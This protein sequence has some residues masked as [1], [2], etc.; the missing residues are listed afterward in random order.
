MSDEHDSEEEEMAISLIRNGSDS[1][2]RL[3][4]VAGDGEYTTC[5]CSSGPITKDICL[6]RTFKFKKK[7]YSMN[8]PLIY[9][10]P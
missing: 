5:Q 4:S 9:A 6:S 2:A 8:Y 1:K 10:K 7:S 3:H